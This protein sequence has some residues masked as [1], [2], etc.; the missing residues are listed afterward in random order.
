MAAVFNLFVN[1]EVDYH[2]ALHEVTM[3][4]INSSDG[5]PTRYSTYSY[6]DKSN[7][8]RLQK[9]FFDIFIKANREPK[10]VIVYDNA[11]TP[12]LKNA[13][14]HHFRRHFPKIDLYVV[15]EEH[16]NLE[17]LQVLKIFNDQDCPLDKFL[18]KS[19]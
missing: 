17:P 10:Q 15:K 16:Q 7:L 6:F 2:S 4:M 3:V 8:A 9:L 14:A 12:Y 11:T 5:S 13:L 1:R 19:G 18:A